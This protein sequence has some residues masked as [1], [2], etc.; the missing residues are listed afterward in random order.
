[1]FAWTLL[2][3]FSL[4]LTFYSQR[5]HTMESAKNIARA[6]FDKDQA[7]RKWASTHGGVYVPVDMNRTP[8]SP[9]LSHLPHRDVTTQ[10]GAKLTLMNPAYMLRQMMDEY[11]GLYGARGHI[12]ALD[13]LNPNSKPDKWEEE[14]LKSFQ[15][16]RKIKEI[17]EVTGDGDSMQMRLIRP[18]Q[19]APSCLKCHAHQ[20]I[21]QGTPTA[22]GVSVT[23]PMKELFTLEQNYFQKSILI[24]LFIWIFGII[25]F[26][27]A[28]TKEKKAKDLAHQLLQDSIK[29]NTK[30]DEQTESLKRSN[31]YKSEFLANM[32]HEI[33]T[34]LNAITGFIKL[35]EKRTQD[36]KSKEYLNI[37]NSSSNSLLQIIEDILDF[38]KIESGKLLIDAI[39]FNMIEEIS[40]ALKLFEAR[41]NEK[42]IKLELCLVGELPTYVHTDPLRIKQVASN[43]ISNA[44]KFTQEGKKIELIVSYKK[45]C[46]FINVKDEGKGVAEDK[47]DHIFESF[48][49]ED[50]STTRKY[51]GTGLG[52][53]ISKE[54]VS[55]MGGEIKVSSTEGIGSEFSFY[56]PAKTVKL[57]E[58]INCKE[59]Q[60]EKFSQKHILLVEDNKSNQ[61]LMRIIL[62][63]MGFS[64]SIANDGKEGVEAFKEGRY[65]L[66]LMDENMPNMDGVEATR[67][68]RKIENENSLEYTPIIALTANALKGAKEY[69]LEAGMDDYLSKPLEQKLLLQVLSKFLS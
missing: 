7:F 55:L 11:A 21:Y 3:L 16:D 66:V 67:N 29:A 26:Q 24:H 32:S 51:G 19:N 10:T 17:L 40:L 35:L 56:I 2:I 34:P 9:Y 48:N 28:Y 68:I 62:E 27:I 59:E 23:V 33:R 53:A 46:L 14:A 6:N 69:F 8:P 15:K 38:S 61:L 60:I 52:L 30:L 57:S 25:A 12:T 39:D 13:I 18:M 5:Q 4:A 41:C 1:M 47:L 54:L 22:G 36:E 31:Q 50:N 45:E 43:L 58:E 37:I 44:I 42:N 49:Q 64:V 20:A 63:E 65:D